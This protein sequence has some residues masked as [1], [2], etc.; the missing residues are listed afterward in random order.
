MIDIKVQ[1]LVQIFD[2]YHEW[3]GLCDTRFPEDKPQVKQIEFEEYFAN[4]ACEIVGHR[5]D[6]DGE[7]CFRCWK[8]IK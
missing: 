3:F 6:E 8:E 7:W 2:K 4:L 1:Q 5:T